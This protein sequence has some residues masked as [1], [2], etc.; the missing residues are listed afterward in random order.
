M[1][2]W[3]LLVCGLMSSRVGRGSCR[4]LL[5]A[6]LIG[7]TV[8]AT[9]G[10]TSY[11]TGTLRGTVLD[12]QAASIANA[13]LTVTNTATG[14]VETEKSSADG[15][16]QFLALNPGT[17]DLEVV[18]Q[19]FEKSV[20]KAL[21]ITVGQIVVYDAHLR[22]GSTTVSVEVN[23]NS[24][25]LIE[26]EQS[27]QANT[28][29]PQQVEN[30]P[31]V[32]RNFTASIYTL[33]GV[34]NSNAPAIQDPNIGTGYLTSGFS[35]GGSTGRSNLFTIDGGEDDYGSGAL[36]VANVP[37]ESIQELQVN[38]NSFGAEFGFT[39]GTAINIITKSGT[40]NYHGS[41]YGYFHDQSTDAANFFNSFSPDPTSKPFEQNAIFGGTFG[42][43][44][45]K[46][47]LFFFTSFEKQKLDNP[48]VTNLLGTAEAQGITAQPNGFNTPGPGLCPGQIPPA[49]QA[50]LVTQNCYL[51]QLAASGTPLAGLGAAFLASPIF[52]PLED[53]ILNALIAPNSGTFDGNTNVVQA[54]PNQNGRLNN[55]VT[56]V[57]FQPDEK[58]SLSFRFS[59]AHENYQVTGQGGAPRYY[60]TNLLVRD[61]TLTGSWTHI[62]NPNLVNTVRVQAVP[63]DTAD[64]A[65]PFPGR[66]EIGLG[67]LGPV[68]TPFAFPYNATQNRFQFDENLSWVKGKHDFKFGGSYR[69]D[70]YK[71]FE[72]LW[73]GG[74]Y[75]FLDGAIPL[76]DIVPAADQ[77]ALATYNVTQGYLP[78][79]P[80]S[81]NLTATESYVVGLPGSFLQANGNGQVNTWNQ[82][83]G[84]FAQDSWKVTHNLTMNYGVRFDYDHSAN[85]VPSSAYA[86][87]RLGFA[88]DP[89][90]DGK[91]VVR[92]GGGLFVAPVIFLVPY[93]LNELGT[94]GLHTN[95]ALQTLSGQPVQI[96]TATA[97]EQGM[98]TLANPNP[99]LTPAQLATPPPLGPGISIVPPGPAQQN[100]VFYTISNNFKPQYSIQSSL[101]VAREIARDLSIEVGYQY[102]RNVHI[103][104]N[105]EANY[106]QNPAIP[107]DP[108]V[109]PFYMPKPGS[110]A[111]EPNTQIL[112]NNQFASIGSGTYNGLTASL[113][114]RFSHGL[115]FQANYTF[116]KAMDD[117]S[118]YSS[119]STPFRPD[120]LAADRSLSDFNITNNFVANAVYTTPFHTDS[121]SFLARAFA[122]VSVSPIVYA[123]SGLPFTLLVPGISS[124]GIAP[125]AA[126]GA[127][128]HI[129]EARPFNEGRNTGIGPGF[130]SWDMRISKGFYI[131]RESSMRLDVIAQA[132]NLLNHT[133]FSSVSNIFPNT[134]V[135]TGGNGVTGGVTTSAEVS[136]PE[137]IVNLLNGP[138]RFKGFVPTS[139]DQLASPLAF[140]SANPPRQLSLGLQF[141]F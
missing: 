138:Y 92:A 99:A 27:Q 117:T 107:V 75:N 50:Q 69:P 126:N 94:S 104:Q 57:D 141:A 34:T 49:G 71:V 72:Q 121:G 114:K 127:G 84:I 66:A 105:L 29:N 83:L 106:V 55:W 5:I 32:A 53:P 60:S 98:A 122:N 129:S 59:L 137:G 10:Q 35:I 41:A 3:T 19:G 21:V 87:P 2:S 16:Y 26:V 42:G 133:N 139:A 110:T 125:L 128:D 47:K 14:V 91:T 132:T 80:A 111:G 56:R 30:L 64:S 31:N 73:F 85:P 89:T 15:S 43:P 135:V 119:L 52:N 70:E 95:L 118:D 37:L 77:P 62:I 109:G 130:V 79:G 58:D 24:A 134:A 100:G 102:Y 12:P 90:G 123:H 25:P 54:V 13:T 74:Q 20:A 9:L 101:S 120:L 93:Y 45:K 18:A 44:I 78:F 46:D 39:A 28:I 23:Y 65:A 17:Y 1:S 124:T 116:S 38:R 136:T 82:Y 113:T 67:S 7:L 115:Q 68:G 103:Q 88:W 11:S 36:R 140:R 131:R 61:Y 48:T 4:L 81:T 8:P 86:S 108:F 96:V 51:T 76:I 112:Q 97:I 33:P 22:L 40:N 63:H 6:V